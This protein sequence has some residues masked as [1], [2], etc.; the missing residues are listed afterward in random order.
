MQHQLKQL[1]YFHKNLKN[2]HKQNKEKILIY[3]QKKTKKKNVLV[4][5]VQ[6]FLKEFLL[7]KVKKVEEKVK[8][9]K[10]VKKVKENN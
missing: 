8:K 7:E 4:K 2:M 3:Q 9:I 5:I 1:I 10:K 6:D